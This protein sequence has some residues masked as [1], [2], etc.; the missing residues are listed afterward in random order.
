M[1]LILTRF[2]STNRRR[3]IPNPLDVKRC[4]ALPFCIFGGSVSGVDSGSTMA[5]SRLGS[6][7]Y[8]RGSTVVC[9]STMGRLYSGSS[10]CSPGGPGFISEV[11]YISGSTVSGFVRGFVLG[12]VRGFGV[13]FGGRPLVRGFG[14]CFGG[15]PQR[16]ERFVSGVGKADGEIHVVHFLLISVCSELETRARS[17]DRWEEVGHLKA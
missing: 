16:D 3:H 8:S 5:Q 17:I 14:V 7:V 12:F 9:G 2:L 4:G 15:R 13:C 10:S 11:D 6:Y 1:T